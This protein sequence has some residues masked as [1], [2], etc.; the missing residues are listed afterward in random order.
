V[1]R[2]ERGANRI[3]DLDILQDKS[4]KDY[5]PSGPKREFKRRNSNASNLSGEGVKICSIEDEW[6]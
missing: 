6:E 2:W 1:K 3:A 4:I 5:K